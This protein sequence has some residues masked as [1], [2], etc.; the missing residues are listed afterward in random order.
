MLLSA[1]KNQHIHLIGIG[2]VGMCGIAEL[3][4]AHGYK[5]SGSD[6]ADN[7]KITHLRELGISV[8]TGHH[9]SHLGHADLVVYSSAVSESNPEWQQAKTKKIPV[10]RRA[11]M[12]SAL[13]DLEKGIAVSGTHGKTTTTG[14][15]IHLLMQA[16][17]KP[18][19][20]IGGELKGV[21]RYA[22][23][24]GGDYF[25]A[26]ADESDASFLFLNPKVAIVTNIDSDHMGTYGGSLECLKQAFLQFLQRLPQEGVAILAEEDVALHS[27]IPDLHCAV[28]TY[29]WSKQ[30]D[31]SAYDFSQ[32]GLKSYFRVRGPGCDNRLFCL[33]LPGKHNVLNALA[34]LGVAHYL[35]IALSDVE[36]AWQ[37]F[38]GVGRRFHIHGNL[39]VP[40]G[41]ALIIDDYGHH[42]HAIRVTLEAAREAWPHRRLVLVFQPH[43]YTRTRDLLLEFAKSLVAADALVILEVYSAGEALIEGA[44]GQALVQAIENLGSLVPTFVPDEAALPAVLQTVL[45]P[46]DVVL[47]VGAGNID[48]MAKSLVSV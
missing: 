16:G 18:T 47:M 34:A 22:A 4:K 5:V 48:V 6:V 28:L 11:E 26:E 15:V 20:S 25:V 39:R 43:R 21:Q 40:G 10:V 30:A 32:E 45:C 29:G 44:D 36:K 42:P 19:Y 46:D 14:L 12:L 13:M 3:L 27:L 35:K 37:S 1:D 8:A 9:A 33:N 2:G 17:L 41:E 23:L 38:P 24:G 7:T 31:F